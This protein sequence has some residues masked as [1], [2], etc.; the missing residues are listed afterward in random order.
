MSTLSHIPLEN[1]HLDKGARFVPFAG[2]NMPVQYTSIIQEH[3]AVRNNVGMFDVSHMGEIILTGNQCEDYLNHLLT[4]DYSN[5]EVGCSRYSMMC[6]DNGGVVDDLIVY[7]LQKQKYLICVNASNTDKDF[8][9]MQ[10]QVSSFDITLDNQSV[11]YGLLAIQGPKSLDF[12]APLTKTDITVLKRFQHTEAVISGV[13]VLI[14]RTGYTGE[15]GFEIYTPSEGCVAV[16]ERINDRVSELGIETFYCGLGCRD[17]LR[18]EAGYPLYGHEISDVIDPITAGMGWTVKL[19]KPEDFVGKSALSTIKS[20]GVS[21]RVKYFRLN[22]RR[23]ARQHEPVWSGE[24]EVGA[25]LSGT[26]SPM[27]EKAIGSLLIDVNH[28]N[29]ESLEVRLRGKPFA[30]T[31]VKPPIHLSV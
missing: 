8:E 30:V 10:E 27:I 5:L 24:A 31:I 22:D 28:M 7:R 2:W 20:N 16:A 9:W 17:S 12:L 23:I 19:K 25:L 15:D 11:A 13:D 26:F 29:D 3:L 6:Y 1:F 21:K 4:N 18:L 14:S